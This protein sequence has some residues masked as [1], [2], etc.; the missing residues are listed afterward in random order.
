MDTQR[1]YNTTGA[2]CPECKALNGKPITSDRVGNPG[3][4]EM[5]HQMYFM[6][7]GRTAACATPH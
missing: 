6:S 4:I 7:D 1:T 3:R 5:G 2:T